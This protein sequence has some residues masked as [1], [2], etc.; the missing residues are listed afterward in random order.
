[1]TKPAKKPIVKKRGFPSPDNRV[2]E[3][4]RHPKQHG[5][6]LD[7]ET[8]LTLIVK[9]EGNVSRVADALGTSR[10]T[11]MERARADVDI[12]KAIKDAR[13]RLIDDI[14]QSVF[15]R[16]RDTKDTALQCFVLKT[17]G[18]H[19]GWDQDEGARM[20]KDIAAEAFA[21]ITNQTKNPAEPT[22]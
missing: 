15:S 21:F 11:I 3:K 2:G 7:K 14:E 13:D 4:A 19:R 18:R 12:D 8:I 6:K 20:A 9:Y 17:Q 22:K 16:A 10:Y 5:R 1:M